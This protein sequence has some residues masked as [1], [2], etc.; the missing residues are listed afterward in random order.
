MKLFVGLDVSSFD[1]KVCFLN[2]DGDQLKSFT[3]AND[4]PGATRLRDEI[5]HTVKDQLVDVLRI[6]LESTSVYS[7]HPSMFLHN[8]SDLRALGAKV[9]VMNPKQIANFKKSY[10][11]MDKTDEIDAF[12]IADY[13][14]F[15]RLPMSVVKEKQYVALQQLTRARYQLV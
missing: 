9:F 7:F 10:S 1:I 4:L 5:L 12:V 2:G 8:D 3:T 14:R 6:G 11:D 15:G 13:L